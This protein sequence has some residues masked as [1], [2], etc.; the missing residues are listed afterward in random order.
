M[1]REKKEN[2]YQY[3][4]SKNSNISNKSNL[5]EGTE[6]IEVTDISNIAKII[7]LKAT[8]SEVSTTIIQSESKCNNLETENESDAELELEESNSNNEESICDESIPNT[9]NNNKVPK[10]SDIS[11]LDQ[12]IA[13]NI[14]D[15]MMFS[16][17]VM[18]TLNGLATVKEL[19]THPSFAYTHPPKNRSQFTIPQFFNNI[20]DLINSFFSNILQVLVTPHFFQPPL[21]QQSF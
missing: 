13:K 12:R 7:D 21:S 19:P 6:V 20:Q 2:S 1:E 8:S 14:T 15:N 3:L 17:W 4:S 11:I 16:T 9:N 5:T 10:I 18:E